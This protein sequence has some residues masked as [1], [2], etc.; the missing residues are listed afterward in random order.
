MYYEGKPHGM[1]RLIP[2]FSVISMCKTIS[3]KKAWFKKLNDRIKSKEK[4]T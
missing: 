3:K 1:Y 4:T 2:L